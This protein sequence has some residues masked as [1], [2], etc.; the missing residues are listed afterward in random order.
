MKSLFHK[1]RMA[2]WMFA[3]LRPLSRSL[4]GTGLGVLMLLALAIAP[5]PVWAV[6]FDTEIVPVLTR[7]GCNAGAC[8]GAAAGRG[9]FRLSLLGG[10]PAADYQ[11]IVHE[12][13][14]RRINLAKP[15]ESVLLAKPTSQLPHGGELVL[16]VDS[17]GAR[18]LIEWIAAGATRDL[19]RKLVEFEVDPESF[20]VEEAGSEVPLRAAAYF[21]D[22]SVED[23]TEWTV[24]TAADP[25]SIAMDAQRNHATVLRGGQHVVVARFLDRVVPIEL[26]LPLAKTPTDLADEPR[27]NFIDEEVLKKL[28]L[29]RLPVAAR[30]ED[31]RYLRRVCLA[32]TGTLPTRDEVEYFLN[33]R[34]ADKRARLVARLLASEEFV[35]YWAFRIALLLRIRALPNERDAARVY[36]DWLREQIRAATPWDEVARELLTATGDSHSVGPANFARSASDARAQAELVSQVFLGARLQCANCHNHPLDRWTQDDYHGLAAVFSRLERG[37]Y[38]ALTA[39]GA[40]T[41]LRTGEPAIPKL[42]GDRF[43]EASADC[44]VELAAWLTQPENP[45]FARAI[46]NRLWQAMFGRGLVEPVDDLRSTNPATHPDLLDRLAADFVAHGCD[47]RHTLRLIALSETFQRGEA[48]KGPD[49]VDLVDDRFYSQALRRPLEPE[50]LADAIASVTGVADVYGNEPIGTRAISLFDPATPA[51][52]LDILGRCSRMASCEGSTT[53]G[54]LP[55][56][57]HRLNGELINSKITASAGRLHQQIEAGASDRDIVNDFYL[58]AL[59]RWPTDAEQKFWQRELSGIDPTERAQRLEDF[60]WSLLNCIEF[61][62]IH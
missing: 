11:A 56:R 48:V 31:A 61:T 59:S 27:A 3:T 23:V 43:I 13:E 57:L 40:V 55:A 38:V 12:L 4:T 17:A 22:G 41:N 51:A 6:D 35:E 36:H 15:D 18:K 62:T 46:V 52:S 45:Y 10:N 34:S 50:V 54:G 33:D 47:L 37:R 9:E 28:A 1:L 21:S 32:L 14:G 49:E 29:L 7:A 20:L 42:P 60:V 19:S 25:A 16:A 8:H 2:L 53:G 58:R 44:R 39:R 30:A 26:T 5:A 24:F